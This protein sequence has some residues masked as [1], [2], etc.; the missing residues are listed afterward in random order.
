M[1]PLTVATLVDARF[2]KKSIIFNYLIAKK[3]AGRR[4]TE[5]AIRIPSK[6]D[7]RVGL[8]DKRSRTGVDGAAQSRASGAQ[9]R[10]DRW[11]W[12]ADPPLR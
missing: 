3:I 11:V 5:E 6:I 10:N 1:Q 12:L 4:S 8:S 7:K 2:N 9:N